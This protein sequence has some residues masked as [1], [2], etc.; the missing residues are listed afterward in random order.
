MRKFYYY[1]YIKCS[2]WKS[3]SFHTW[4]F[5]ILFCS[6]SVYHC[7]YLDRCKNFK[8][9]SRKF[10]F[11]ITYYFLFFLDYYRYLV[12]IN[13]LAESQNGH[14]HNVCLTLLQ[15]A[16]ELDVRIM[17]DAEQTYFQPAISRITVEMMGKY[18]K[19]KV[20]IMLV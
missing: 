18:N 14:L 8:N 10:S 1:D 16:Q 13:F 5:D 19:D 12:L 9:T 2:K 20:N 11:V 6:T 3:L 4:F 7:F 15:T 17:I